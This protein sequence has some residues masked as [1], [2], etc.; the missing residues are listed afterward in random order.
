[1]KTAIQILI[2]LLLV[3]GF[4][5]CAQYKAP[6]SYLTQQAFPDSVMQVKWNTPTGESSFVQ[7]LEKHK[8]KKIVIDFWASWC[9][10]C[11]V[12]L[13]KVKQLMKNTKKENVAYVFISVDKDVGKWK[14]AIDK[15]SIKGDHYQ[16]QSGWKNA[17]THYIDLDWIPRYIVIDENGNVIVPKAISADDKTLMNAVLPQ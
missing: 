10:D 2:P 3:S 12:G 16:S 14:A 1:M 17:L 4:F 9:K 5:S 15:F 11:I 8:G 7:L 6:P 13:P